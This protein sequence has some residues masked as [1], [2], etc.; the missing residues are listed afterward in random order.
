MRRSVR[1]A[2]D[3]WQNTRI[4]LFSDPFLFQ[5]QLVI[6]NISINQFEPN[7]QTSIAEIFGSLWFAAPKSKISPSRKRQKHMKFFPDRINWGKCDR[8]GE[9]KRPHRICTDHKEFCGMRDEE[10]EEYRLKNASEDTPQQ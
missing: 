8:C 7:Q 3:S 9:P 4:S 1:M 2:V 6:S 10:Y 5:P